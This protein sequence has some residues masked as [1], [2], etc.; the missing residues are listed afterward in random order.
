MGF[1][2]N[3]MLDKIMVILRGF[4]LI[5]LYMFL[6]PILMILFKSLHFSDTFIGKNITYI[7][8][9]LVTMLILIAIFHQRF[10]KDWKDF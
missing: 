9:E 1:K 4:G 8:A 6:A 2:C 3:N 7:L 10:F 5:M